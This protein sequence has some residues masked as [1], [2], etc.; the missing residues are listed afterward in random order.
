[1]IEGQVA[2]THQLARARLDVASLQV[3]G[4]RAPQKA[5]DLARLLSEVPLQQRVSLGRGGRQLRELSR[6]ESPAGLLHRRQR[7]LGLRE[8]T[9]AQMR[10]QVCLART[11]RSEV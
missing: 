10:A 6:R 7:G 8:R 4:H 2:R 3:P 9:R 1:M 11:L 5:L